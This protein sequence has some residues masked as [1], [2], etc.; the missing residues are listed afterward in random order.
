MKDAPAR[1]RGF[2]GCKLTYSKQL[3][4]LTM[5]V[6]TGD[7]EVMVLLTMSVQASTADKGC[8]CW[9]GVKDC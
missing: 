8:A 2:S 6:S 5:A 4:S 1:G 3:M 7:E 9:A